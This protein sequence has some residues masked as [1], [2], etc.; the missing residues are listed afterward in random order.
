LRGCASGEDR[1]GGIDWPFLILRA[2]GP[3]VDNQT[4]ATFYDCSKV[5]HIEQTDC[6]GLAQTSHFGRAGV[7]ESAEMSKSDQFRQYAEEALQWARQSKTEN[8]K[9]ALIELARTWTQAAVQGEHIFGV[10]DN[11]PG[12]QLTAGGR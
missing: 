10:N 8:E 3:F 7:R 12:R 6:R 1:Q 4:Q 9:Q 11:A 5:F 2:S